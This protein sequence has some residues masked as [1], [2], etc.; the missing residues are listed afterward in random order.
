MSWWNFLFASFQTCAFCHTP[1]PSRAKSFWDVAICPY[2]LQE[3][4]K[5]S[6]KICER[7]GRSTEFLPVCMD[8]R[9]VNDQ[10]FIA[11]RSVVHYNAWAKELI[12]RLKY[13]GQVELA[14]PM[15]R[16]MASLAKE[17]YRN[18]RFSYITY[19][20]LHPRKERE[21]G[22]NQAKLLAE[23]MGRSLMLPVRET[24]ERVIHTSP[25]SKR[26][27]KQRLQAL[28]GAFR[29]SFPIGSKRILLVDDVY[30]TGATLR[31]C[32]SLLQAAG[33]REIYSITFAR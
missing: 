32:A 5:I 22:Y 9:N 12:R 31:E 7:C 20:P 23:Q 11:N 4:E 2:C 10:A 25:Q 15:G 24:L 27:K 13:L 30:T 17:V 8:C 14:K 28:K 1:L 19:V 18:Y 3:S 29:C 26:D 16:W 21:R 6:G 33:A